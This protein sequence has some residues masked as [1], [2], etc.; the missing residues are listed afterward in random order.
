MFENCIATYSSC[1]R[2]KNYDLSMKNAHLNSNKTYPFT[3]DPPIY[4]IKAKYTG[5]ETIESR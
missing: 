1:H 4:Y 5:L 3:H 2:A